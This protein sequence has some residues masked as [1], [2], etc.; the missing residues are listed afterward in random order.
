MGGARHARRCIGGAAHVLR[1]RGRV[2][3]HAAAASAAGGAPPQRR[4]LLLLLL[5]ALRKRH[6][7]PQR[8]RD[9]LHLV[10]EAVVGGGRDRGG[11][12]RHVWSRRGGCHCR[13]CRSSRRGGCRE[14]GAAGNRRCA[15]GSGRRGSGCC[16]SP[17]AAHGSSGEGAPEVRSPQ[18]LLR[19]AT[20]P[21]RAPA[22]VLSSGKLGAAT[23]RRRASGV[24]GRHRRCT[25]QRQAILAV[26]LGPLTT[27]FPNRLCAL[28]RGGGRRRHSGRGAG[29]CAC[30]ALT[31]VL[32]LLRQG[33]GGG[34]G[35]GGLKQ[36][37]GSGLSAVLRIGGHEEDRG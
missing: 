4:A 20:P 28:S 9:A 17:V 24:G 15:L 13:G 7:L 34:R 22:V 23:A 10:V 37:C 25:L 35:G 11:G 8:L 30:S 16:L 18:A 19:P 27:S 14:S 5:Q 29:L 26:I 3:R 36:R 32:S 12:D 2:A 21:L 1:V 6:V 31:R 33:L